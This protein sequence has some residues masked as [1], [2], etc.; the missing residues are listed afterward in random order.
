M[1]CSM[2]QGKLKT[3]TNAKP[4]Q[5]KN[6]P[7]KSNPKG[8]VHLKG[9]VKKGNFKFTAKKTAQQQ[10]QK[11]KKAVEKGINAKIETE[12]KAVAVSHHEGKQF[13]TIGEPKAGSSK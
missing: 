13:K 5:K 6:K 3:K 10:V 8:G 11:F 12:L 9:G 1:T 2:A 7:G 4:P